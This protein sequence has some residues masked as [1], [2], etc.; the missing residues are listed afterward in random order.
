MT[1][2]VLLLIKLTAGELALTLCC[3]SA[4]ARYRNLT[5]S[6]ELKAAYGI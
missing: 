1:S 3:V 2:R 6:N 4:P 5:R